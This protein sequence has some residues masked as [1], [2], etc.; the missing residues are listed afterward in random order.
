MSR[1]AAIEYLKKFGM[2]D[3]VVVMEGSAATVESAAVVVGCEKGQIAKSL[4]YIVDG[5][6]VVVLVGG[7]RRV[8]NAKFKAVFGKRPQMIKFEEVEAL[9]G[10]APGGVCPFGLKDGVRVYIDESLRGLDV[11]YPAAGD[12]FSV[13]RFTLEELERI[14]GYTAYVDVSKTIAD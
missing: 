9:T 8:D 10:H 6:P 2:D 7:D 13:A 11:V 5:A 12:E 4:S 3:R 1:Q 14:T